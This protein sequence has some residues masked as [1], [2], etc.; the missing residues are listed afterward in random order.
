M[1]LP[2]V[3]IANRSAIEAEATRLALYLELDDAGFDGLLAWV[4]ELRAQVGIPNTLADLGLTGE[5]AAWVGEQALAD[6]SSSET[7]A[8]PLTAADYTRIY[9]NA[10]AG[11]LN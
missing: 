4:L 5:D 9:R 2:Y 6:I 8:L 11:L 10:V 3:L 1:L 7:N